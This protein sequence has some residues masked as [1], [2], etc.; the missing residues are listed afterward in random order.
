MRSGKDVRRSRI[1]ISAAFSH[2]CTLMPADMPRSRV[3][4]ASE[5]IMPYTHMVVPIDQI[6]PHPRNARTHSKKQVR[7]IAASIR[8]LGFAAPILI[9]EKKKL[10]AGHGRDESPLASFGAK[11]SDAEIE[12]HLGACKPLNSLLIARL[13]N[14]K[15]VRAPSHGDLGDVRRQVSG[16]GAQTTS[17]ANS[18]A[19]KLQKPI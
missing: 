4:P 13:S 6:R 19:C 15:C 3:A 14:D 9:D 11:D 7:Q 16:F 1:V 2:R 18:M 5:H 8:A 10:I 12:V 17:R